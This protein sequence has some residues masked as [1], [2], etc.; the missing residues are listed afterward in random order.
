MNT[1]IVI[2][3]RKGSKSIPNKN[4]MMFMD[5]PLYEWTF[6]IS[7]ECFDRRIVQGVCLVSDDYDLIRAAEKYGFNVIYEPTC[8]AGDISS[9]INWAHF[10]ITSLDLIHKELDAIMHLRVTHPF[11]EP[12]ILDDA[13]RVAKKAFEFDDYDSLRSVSVAKQSP[14]KM[15]F[16]KDRI[17]SPVIDMPHMEAYNMP[18]QILSVA[19]WQNG[20]V[21]IFKRSCVLQKNS[22]TGTKIYPYIIESNLEIDYPSDLPGYTGEIERE[23]VPS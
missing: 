2:P 12:D 10:V 22:M 15:W 3:A 5:K 18:R 21:D 11:R 4:K 6:D 17:L 1:Y 23:R 19:Y 7:K 16:I 14:W 9:D 13:L 8:I 20:Y